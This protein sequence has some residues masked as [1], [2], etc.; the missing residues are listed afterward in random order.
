MSMIDA[1]IAGLM[2][3]RPGD[4]AAE[5][6]AQAAGGQSAGGSGMGSS[7]GALAGAAIGSVVP[8]LG[9]LVG[10]AVGSI[11]GG[12]AEKLAKPEVPAGPGATIEGGSVDTAQRG[13]V[14]E[15][16]LS[17]GHSLQTLAMRGL[18]NRAAA[19][20]RGKTY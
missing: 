8:G 17:V 10:G 16:A 19:N 14:S 18:N 9:T 2:T 4:S 15:S 1:A 12:G 13:P 3:P 11:V 7:V 5:N 20:G 6:A